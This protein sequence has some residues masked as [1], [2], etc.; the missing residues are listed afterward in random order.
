MKRRLIVLSAAAALLA[1]LFMLPGPVF[2][3]GNTWA[4]TSLAQMVEAARWRL[5]TL[6]VNA[7]LALTNAGYDSDIYFG[8]LD[9]AVPDYT[10]T[11]GVP[12]QVLLPLSK[13]VVLE[14]FDS[15]QYLF[16]LGT[17]RERAWNNIF[18]GKVHFAFD[19]F[20]IQAGGGLSNIRQRLSPELNINIRQKED[21]LNGTILWQVSRVISLGLLYVGSQFDY[22]N[23]EF[24]GTS[25]ADAL[26][27]KESYFDFVAYL[28]PNSRVRFFVDGQYGTYA[29]TEAASSFKGTRSY[30]VFGG[31]AFVPREGE[32]RPVE[33]VQ[34]SISLGYKLF[35]ILDPLRADGSGF[36][37]AVDV[38]AGLF[39][40]TTGRAFISRDFAFSV[41]SSGTF[42]LSTNYGGGV[43]RQLSRRATFSY[44][45]SFSQSAY[46]QE[47]PGSGIPTGQGYR[48]TTHSFRLS[49]RLARN[50]AITFLGT[51]SEGI[52]DNSGLA[53]N[54]KFFGLN[55]VYG[56]AAG[57]ISA[58]A[59]GLSR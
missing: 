37:G 54:R 18:R 39:K 7:A 48:Y 27:R 21:S 36:V 22:G 46:P 43:S 1:W 26:N 51:L 23:A 6:R 40:K 52:L 41:Y 13:K 19:R 44:D 47:D 49:I 34:G 11:A 31:L 10:F 9:E 3:Q 16:Y 25:I 42:L 35:D 32:S 8:Y 5:G 4:G 2:G 38:S 24:G 29:F 57:A 55:M 15:P 20:Y 59:R 58:P 28:Q 17:I 33:P 14:V 56:F 12:V 53:K 45:L 50:L 30:G